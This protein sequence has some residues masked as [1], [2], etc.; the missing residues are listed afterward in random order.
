MSRT[1]TVLMASVVIALGSSSF[2]VAQKAG[3]PVLQGERNGTTRSETEIVSDIRASAGKKGGYSTR[4]SN[5]SSSGGGAIYGCR[6]TSAAGT[7]PCVRANN[8]SS[9]KAFEFNATAGPSAGTITVGTGGDSKKPFT[10]N[11]TGVADGL[12]ADRVDGLNGPQLRTRWLLVNAAGVIER[13]SGGFRIVA[14]YPA[15][16]DA[17][18][19]NVYIDAGEDLT[20][21]G[22]T[23]T[24]ALQNSVNQ[25]GGTMNGTNGDDN[26][27]NEGDNLEFSGEISATQCQLPGIVA[28]APEGARNPNSFLVSPRLSNGERTTNDTRKRFYVMITE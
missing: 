7:A 8:L 28:C 25:R 24:I 1:R 9:G 18:N 21:N 12:N 22:I 6:S 17:A 2:A 3:K 23:A 19:G 16:P 11:A 4:Q 15:N 20:D 26:Q 10:T 5:K 27:P 13:Q 14:A